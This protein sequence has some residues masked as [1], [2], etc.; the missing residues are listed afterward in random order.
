MALSN[1]TDKKTRLPQITK[2]IHSN[3]YLFNKNPLSP[4]KVYH[5]KS[6]IDGISNNASKE[7]NKN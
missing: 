2:K 5:V 3:Q 6:G 7:F 4:E 1:E